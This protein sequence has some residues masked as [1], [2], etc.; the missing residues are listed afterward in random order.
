MATHKLV[1]RGT[2]DIKTAFEEILRRVFA[3][4]S[5]VTNNKYRYTNDP[6]TT[7]IQIY[8]N[9]PV[10]AAFY[11]SITLSIG[12]FDASVNILGIQNEPLSEHHDDGQLVSQT[13]GG[14]MQIP[15]NITVRAKESQ[16]DRDILRDYV[17][18]V[19][20]ILAR[21]EF[22]QS[23]LGI[24]QITGGGDE[25]TEDTDGTLIY[26]STITLPLNTDYGYF[27]TPDANALINSIVVDV[28]GRETAD[29][30]SQ[31]LHEEPPFT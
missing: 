10:R 4:N 1:F 22:A 18:Q 8:R 3:D 31:P 25:E 28:W 21:H 26:S 15:L 9:F 16:D 13:Y 24:H 2:L 7:K 19:C 30:D 11:P 29:A 17:I 5:I 27:T 12:E 23:G 6:E 20:R 14:A